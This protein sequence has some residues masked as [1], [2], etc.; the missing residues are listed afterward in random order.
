MPARYGNDVHGIVTS[1]DGRL[2][3]ARVTEHLAYPDR[4]LQLEEAYWFHLDARGAVARVEIFWQ[5]PEADP[6]GFGSARSVEGDAGGAPA[7]AGSREP[8][9]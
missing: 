4:E 6:G 5:T 8:G 1:A 3:C 2:A 7:D 9:G